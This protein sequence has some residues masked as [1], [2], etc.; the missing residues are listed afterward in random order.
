VEFRITL[1]SGFAPP[2][3]AI[4]LLWQRLGADYDEVSFAKVGGEIWATLLE[5][6]PSSMNWDERAEICRLVVSDI[7]HR[8]CEQAVELE[9]D[10]FAVSSG[11]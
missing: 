3:D 4:D 6:P 7:V 11:E 5:D 1:H 10:W 8:V 9:W 2:A